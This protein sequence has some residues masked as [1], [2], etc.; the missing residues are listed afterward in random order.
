MAIKRSAMTFASP[1][2]GKGEG[3][4]YQVMVLITCEQTAPQLQGKMFCTLTTDT[5]SWKRV[6]AHS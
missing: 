2:M 4:L 5:S 6:F 1:C 3:S